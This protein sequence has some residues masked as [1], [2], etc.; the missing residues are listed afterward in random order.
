[1]EVDGLIAQIHKLPPVSLF[2]LV[3]GFAIARLPQF[4]L[5]KDRAALEAR[6]TLIKIQQQQILE[7][8]AEIKE[9]KSR[10]EESCGEDAT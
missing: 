10:Y 1:V 3:I 7:L 8:R 4:I 5:Q 2:L 6:D 9:L